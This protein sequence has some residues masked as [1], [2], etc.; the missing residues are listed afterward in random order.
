MGGVEQHGG[1]LS[2]PGLAGPRVV[3]LRRV[4]R[5][6]VGHSCVDGF[7]LTA[8]PF[9]ET[10]SHRPPKLTTFWHLISPGLVSPWK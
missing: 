7:Y 2:G 8:F 10:T 5:A 9:G 1:I 6:G 3:L 4:G